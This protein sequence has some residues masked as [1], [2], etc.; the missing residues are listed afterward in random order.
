M[1]LGDCNPQPVYDRFAQ[2][3][4][5]ID[6]KRLE[7]CETEIIKTAKEVREISETM[8]VAQSKL[9]M[10]FRAGAELDT[11]EETAARL[12][13]AIFGGTPHSKLFLNVR[14]KLK[15]C[16]YCA[17]RYNS[18]KG[19]MFVESGVETQNLEGAKK[20]ILAQLEEIRT[21]QLYRGR[22]PIGKVKHM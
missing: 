6:R 4:S 11:P 13:V 12:M 19:V 18:N 14:E 17:A 1:V 8:S 7:I 20:E 2:A 9:V 21:R 10:G 22:N 15:L 3:F 5:K 16:Y